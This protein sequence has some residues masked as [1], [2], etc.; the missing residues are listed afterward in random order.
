MHRNM[1]ALFCD[2]AVAE[3]TIMQQN[4][5]NCCKSSQLDVDDSFWQLKLCCQ[6]IAGRK[7]MVS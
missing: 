7:V 1:Q 2:A 5:Q 6:E 4:I 3:F